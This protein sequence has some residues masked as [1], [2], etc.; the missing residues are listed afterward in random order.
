MWHLNP[1]TAKTFNGDLAG[2]WKRC[3]YRLA[4]ARQGLGGSGLSHGERFSLRTA[5]HSQFAVLELVAALVLGAGTGLGGNRRLLAT[6]EDTHISSS[7]IFMLELVSSSSLHHSAGKKRFPLQVPVLKVPRVRFSTLAMLSP[8]ATWELPS[9][10]V[11]PPSSGPVQL[12]T[13]TNQLAPNTI[14]QGVPRPLEA[15]GQ[16]VSLS[17]VMQLPWLVQLSP[18]IAPCPFAYGWPQ[19]VVMGML[20]PHQ[21]RD[22]VQG[23][24]LYPTGSGALSVHHQLALPGVTMMKPEA[25]VTTLDPR[26]PMDLPKE[27]PTTIT[28]AIPEQAEDTTNQ[29]LL[30]HPETP[31]TMAGEDTIPGAP[32]SL[33]FTDLMDSLFEWLTDGDC[34]KEQVV[35]AQEDSEDTILAANVPSLMAE[36][37]DEL[38][39]FC[40]SLLED[41]CPRKP[42]VEA[43]QRNSKDATPT[44][45]SLTLC[46][47]SPADCLPQPVEEVAMQRQLL[48]GN[49]TIQADPKTRKLGVAR[50]SAGRQTACPRVKRHPRRST[51]WP[52]KRRRRR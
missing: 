42:A 40:D 14:R 11:L 27:G 16:V 22:V 12:Y 17:P 30:I 18:E 35:A 2:E 6:P 37:L 28:E 8:R 34:P 41:D 48:L 4:M 1:A 9:V 45:P 5:E 13:C 52:A 25:V 38:L 21:P 15:L 7:V 51:S 50:P 33:T 39:E 43:Q 10:L 29:H 44:S 47:N 36:D 26:K 46:I 31:E 23:E 20:P 24:S 19:Q 32:N 3:N 49:A